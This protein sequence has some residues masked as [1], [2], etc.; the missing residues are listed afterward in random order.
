MVI[1]IVTI[2]SP[3]VQE[4]DPELKP[5]VTKAEPTCRQ[6]GVGAYGSV[7]QVKVEGTINVCSK[8]VQSGDLQEP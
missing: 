8:K 3:K 7:E 6:L 1:L 4:D 5:L 2:Y